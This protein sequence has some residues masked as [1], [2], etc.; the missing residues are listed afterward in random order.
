[1]PLTNSNDY[2]TGRKPGVSPAGS[3]VVAVRFAVDLTTAD[4]AVNRIGEIG[5]LP[6][7]C[8]PVQMIVDSDDLDTNA[9]PT[10]AMSFGVLNA[11]GTALST[12]ADD[13]G[14]AWATGVTVGQAGGAVV[15]MSRALQRV[16]QAQADRKIGVSV[17]AGAATAAAGTLGLT[18]LY[19]AA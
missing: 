14:A 16:N 3:E 19:R 2:L 17:T 12:A 15:P 1:M 18:L 8:V 6:A 9:T 13:G 11:A 7:G 4:L 10:I 5:V